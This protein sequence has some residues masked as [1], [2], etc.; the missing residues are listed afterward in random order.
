MVPLYKGGGRL[1]SEPDSFRPIRLI[2]SMAKLFEKFVLDSLEISLTRA[3]GIS[4]RQYGFKRETGTVEAIR[5]VVDFAEMARRT[6]STERQ[7][8]LM[9]IL[10]VQNAFITA[11]RSTGCYA[12]REPAIT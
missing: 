2:D 4:A 1:L 10:D 6:R 9:V 5:R 12:R 8:S 11:R 3:G 7:M